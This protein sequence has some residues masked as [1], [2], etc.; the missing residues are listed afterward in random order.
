LAEGERQLLTVL[1]LLR[2]TAEE[3]ALFVLDEPDTHLN[4]AWC[5]DYLE[6]LRRYGANLESS[7]IIMTTHNPVTFAGLDRTEVVVMQRRDGQIVAEHPNASPRGMGFAAILT[8]EIFGLRSTLDRET[9]EDVERLRLL[10]AKSER[11]QQEEKELA[12]LNASLA[13][14]GFSRDFRDPLFKEFVQEMAKERSAQPDLWNQVLT[15][16]QKTQRAELVD[17]AVRRLRARQEAE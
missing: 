13:P 5:L 3:E 10:A 8:S 7:Q 2:F 17:A 4:P 6:N 11:T 15:S 12:Q 1:G 14:L 16:D 9:L